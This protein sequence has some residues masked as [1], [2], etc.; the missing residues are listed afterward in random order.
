M[1]YERCGDNE[2]VTHVQPFEI[3]ADFEHE[4]FGP[5]AALGKVVVGPVRLR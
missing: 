3:L 1:V 4:L 5:F 2:N